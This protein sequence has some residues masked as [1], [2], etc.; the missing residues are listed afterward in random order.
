[1]FKLFTKCVHKLKQCSNLKLRDK[2]CT[3]SDDSLLVHKMEEGEL[4]RG[5]EVL[6]LRLADMRG[7]YSKGVLIRRK[8]GG[9]NS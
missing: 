3:S 6:I 7:S 1:M 9:A 4:I 5:K 8:G 2:K